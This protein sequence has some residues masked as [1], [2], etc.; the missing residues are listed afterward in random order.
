[1]PSARCLTEPLDRECQGFGGAS[2]VTMVALGLETRYQ[3]HEA[4]NLCCDRWLC[5]RQSRS[6]RLGCSLCLRARTVDTLRICILD[7]QFGDGTHRSHRSAAVYAHRHPDRPRLRLRVPHS[8][9][10]L[11]RSSLAWARMEKQPRGTTTASGAMAGA[12]SVQ[13]HVS[14]PVALGERP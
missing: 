8:R 11:S 6:R 9:D 10:A 4:T 3:F 14:Y 5:H 1:M 13:C 7:D 2:P 12:A